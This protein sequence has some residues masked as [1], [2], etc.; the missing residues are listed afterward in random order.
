MEDN[1]LEINVQT[2][3]NL[4]KLGKWVYFLAWLMAVV[5][6]VYFVFG[7]IC[8]IWNTNI[9][10]TQ[11]TPASGYFVGI[12]LILCV[13]LT[14]YPTICLFKSG[15]H[16]KALSVSGDE[17]HFEKGTGNLKSYFKFTGIV[18]IVCIAFAVIA[19]IVTSLIALTA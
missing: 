10:G 14:V 8:M 13:A 9:F 15:K 11:D 2:R 18:A 1:K 5:L 6:A 3:Y 19:T 12:T 17:D 4:V 7:I 16:L